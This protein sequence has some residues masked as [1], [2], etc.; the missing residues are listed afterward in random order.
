MSKRIE[1]RAVRKIQELL[2]HDYLQQY[3]SINDKEPSWDGNI[4]VHDSPSESKR[5]II[6]RVPIQVKG[7]TVLD[8]DNQ[9]KKV[10]VADL[11]NYLKDGGVVYFVVSQ[12]D[13]PEMVVYYNSLTP[14]KIKM[15]LE[16]KS[17]QESVSISFRRFPLKEEKILEVF[18]DFLDKSKKESSFYKK[19][20]VYLH[21]IKDAEFEDGGSFLFQYRGKDWL[22]IFEK[23]EEGELGVYFLPANKNSVPIPLVNKIK[24]MKIFEEE[25]IEVSILGKVYYSSIIRVRSSREDVQIRFG[26]SF[27]LNI[28]AETN[29]GNLNIKMTLETCFMEKDYEFLKGLMEN[30]SFTIFGYVIPFSF[31]D[32]E[33]SFINS[34]LNDFKYLTKIPKMLRYLGM[35]SNYDLNL[36]D[37]NDKN[38]LIAYS[39]SILDGEPLK[40]SKVNSYNTYFVKNDLFGILLYA[41]ETENGWIF[42]DF[43]EYLHNQSLEKCIDKIVAFNI[44]SVD[45]VNDI[46]NFNIDYLL[47][48]YKRVYDEGYLV[49]NMDLALLKLI[50]YADNSDK[51]DK[52]LLGS[53]LNFSLWILTIEPHNEENSFGKL[54]T[55]QIKYRMESLESEEKLNLA[56]ILSND[57]SNI[58]E[59]FGASVLLDDEELAQK[60]Y[61]MFS[62]EDKKQYS[63]LPIKTLYDNLLKNNSTENL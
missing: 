50:N 24:D 41:T 32:S 18:L 62:S 37:N 29:Q 63:D 49:N 38:N 35:N 8:L 25:S 3:I 52:D 54:N 10:S 33:S 13:Y 53:L 59:K 26:K 7:D 44:L 31:T 47:S 23:A 57:H 48:L 56:Q 4:Y 27:S 21:E 43:F 42:N 9:K 2:D 14:N 51:H 12:V 58:Y 30:K 39:E 1:E 17:N 19:P 46:T 34:I 36:L 6:G 40:V 28:D 22:S 11:K 20:L 60:Y 45:D 15:I 16:G 61:D 55:Y 5:T